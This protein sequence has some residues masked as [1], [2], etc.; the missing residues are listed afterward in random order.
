MPRWFGSCLVAIACAGLAAACGGSSMAGAGAA[1]GQAGVGVGGGVG[2]GVGGSGGA[3]GGGG[4]GGSTGE[5]ASGGARGTGG[6]GGSG[7]GGG[8][9]GST[10]GSP[11]LAIV[12]SW[13][14]GVILTAVR[15]VTSPL[16]SQIVQ[17]HN[18][19]TSAATITALALGGSNPAAFQLVG[20]PPLPV[21]L[22]AGADLPVTIA[23]LTTAAAL[24]AAPPQNSGATLV[25]A[26]LTASAGAVSARVNLFGLVLTTA[27]HEP[28][29]GQILVTLG[30]ALDVGAAQNNA[31]PISPSDASKLAGIET[32]SDE[33]AAPLFA[34]AAP[35]NVTLA[36]VARFSPKGPMPFGWYPKGSPTTRNAAATMASL[37]DAQTSDKARMVLSPVTGP[38]SFDPGSAV[39]GVWVY[40]DQLSQK[41]DTGGTASNGDY[42]YSE[43]GPNAPANVHRAKVY[44]LRDA[45][46]APVAN[47]YLIAVEEAGNGDYQDYVF[48]LGNVTVAP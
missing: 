35:G 42:A 23:V 29:L 10:S 47:H 32:T 34:K 1:G 44:P 33:I 11:S 15:E 48:V 24:P 5:A 2:A 19:G 39:F 36:A 21:V 13:P 4:A 40:T 31:N 25:T 14:N 28:T 38:Q 45:T 12:A 30:Y 26:T 43:D 22:A 37:A 7:M 18:T 20:P 46:G 8:S 41:Y 17:V 27:T 9:G 16:A 3:G 6:V